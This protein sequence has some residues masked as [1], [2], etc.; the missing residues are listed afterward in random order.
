M[1]VN[2]FGEKYKAGVSMLFCAPKKLKLYEKK[3]EKKTSFKC[4]CKVTQIRTWN[5]D[6]IIT[7]SKTGT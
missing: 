5:V 7:L 1:L 4:V 3:T 2:W 6:F